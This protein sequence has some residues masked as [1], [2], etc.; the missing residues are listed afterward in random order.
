MCIRDSDVTVQT[1]SV[2]TGNKQRDDHL[3]S[4]DFF[5]AAQFP[6]IRFKSKS[7]ESAAAANV[8]MVRGDLT[9]MGVTK[10]VDVLVKLT[11]MGERGRFGYRA[12]ISAEF[13]INRSEFGQKVDA[14]VGDEVTLLIALEGMR[15]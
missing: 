6:T 2:D 15:E 3:R 5:N 12:G 4:A 7:A 9:M 11:G 8:W 13:K 14:G 10:E 1:A